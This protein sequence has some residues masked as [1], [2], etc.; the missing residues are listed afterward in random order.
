MSEHRIRLDDEDL[1]RIEKSLVLC[2]KDPGA[3]GMDEWKAKDLLSRFRRTRLH[4]ISGRPTPQYIPQKRDEIG[5]YHWKDDFESYLEEL[6]EY[7]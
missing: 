7:L 6:N 3:K 1:A 5:S 2:L 4:G